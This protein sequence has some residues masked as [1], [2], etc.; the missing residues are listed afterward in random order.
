MTS[1]SAAN[2]E[3]ANAALTASRALL[4]VVARSVASALDEVS[5]PQFR[6]LVLLR[7]RGPLRTGSLAERLGVNASTF[8]RSLDKIVSGGWVERQANPGSRREIIIDLTDKGR[9][10]VDGVTEARRRDLH[11]IL[12]LLS[13]D[14]Q[15]AVMRAFALFNAAAGEPSAEELLTLGI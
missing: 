13:A 2:S 3:A 7:S 14:Q 4:G 15:D 8:S 6:V 1:K 12:A 10:L 5:L 11:A 9:L